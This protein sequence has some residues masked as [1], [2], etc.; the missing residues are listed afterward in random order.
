MADLSGFWV[1]DRPL[2]LLR[3]HSGVVI[4]LAAVAAAALLVKLLPGSRRDS[5]AGAARRA[6]T[7]VKRAFTTN[8]Q[9][10]LLATTAFVLSCASG[11]TTWDGMRNFTGEP[12]LSFMVTFGIQG[13]MLII[14]WIIGES[15]ASGMSHRPSRRGREGGGEPSA[16]SRIE[17]AVGLIVGTLFAI[18][19]FAAVANGLGAFESRVGAAGVGTGWSAFADKALYAGVGLL[20]IATLV[21]NSRSDIAQPYVQSARIIAKNAVLWVM[22][23]ACM[24]TSVFFSFD[25]LF[26]SI[27][28]QDERKRAAEIRAVNQ[29]AGVVADI[30]VL[31]QR[32]QAEE[33]DA[34]F[35]SEG[36]KRYDDNLTRLAKES[37]GAEK[38]IEGFFVEQMEARRR[39][40]AEQQ[41]RIATSQSGQAGLVSKKA[42]MTD[43]LS[44]LKA[45]RPELA[46]ILAKVKSE[47]DE[48]A[49]NLDAKRIEAQAEEK[50]AEGTLKQGRGPQWR[51]RMAELARLQEAYK[52]QEE[53][54]REAQKR[55]AAVDTRLAQLERELAAVDGDIAKLKGE[56]ATA[57]QRITVAEQAKATEEG[58]PKVDPARVR[59]AFERA[60]ADFVR[61]PTAER[62]IGLTSQCIQLLGAMTATPATKER[63]RAIDCDAKQAAE[64][65]GR[66]FALNAGIQT[67]AQSCAGGDKLPQTGGTDALLQFGRKCLQ[68][69]GLPSRDS[70]EMAG[71]ISSIDLNRDDK[72]HRFVVT[73]NAFLDG[74]RLAYLALAIAIAIDSLVFMSGLFGANAVRSPLTDVPSSKARSAEQLEAVIENALLP[75]K[76]ENARIALEAMHATTGRPGFVAEVDTAEL[77]PDSRR[78]VQ[79][80]LTAGST[81]GAVE[82]DAGRRTRYH[83][84]GELYEFLAIVAKR[85]FEQNKKRF[86]EDIEQSHARAEFE[87]VMTVALLPQEEIGYNCDLVLSHLTPR[88]DADKKTGF[89]SEIALPQYQPSGPMAGETAEDRAARLA[90]NE[91]RRQHNA[92]DRR[93]MMR[94][95]NA[96]ATFSF[97]QPVMDAATRQRIPDAYYVHSELYKMLAR[98]RARSLT[99]AGQQPPS[100]PPSQPPVRRLREA[101]PP[102]IEPTQVRPAIG[103]RGDQQAYRDAGDEP[104]PTARGEP[105]PPRSPRAP[106]EPVPHATILP[107]IP[108]GTAPPPPAAAAAEAPPPPRSR[109][110]DSRPRGT[111][112]ESGLKNQ[113]RDELIQ[114]GGLFPWDARD[115]AVAARLGE[116]SEPEAALRRLAARAPRLGRLVS[117][118][119]EDYR[120]SVRQAYEDLQVRNDHQP[121]I[122][123]QVLETVR[124]ELIQ[125]MPLLMLS[126]GG[127]YQQILDHMISQLEPQDGDGLLSPNDQG[128][129]ARARMQ[130]E[131]LKRLADD[132]R[133][134]LQHV[135]RIIDQ[136][137]ER[138]YSPFDRQPQT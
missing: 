90:E 98:I 64:A 49:R 83:I 35:K 15:F 55:L 20:L 133:H 95:L 47:L 73:W 41:E 12:I 68:D 30:G 42:T 44:R 14:A 28:P 36:W 70:A 111:E 97:V 7:A 17:P 126:P 72:A 85:T 54:V 5:S 89:T 130:V 103:Y 87:R 109:R 101:P 105:E 123:I 71:K 124:D 77:D 82:Q 34:L 119:V 120:A 39:A 107:S 22:F 122:Y 113:I 26:S 137:D 37:Q 115:L 59:N 116:D 112:F 32:R 74:N 24:A 106:V 69:S 23:L 48:R 67:F 102:V 78:R 29:V 62:L 94:V 13:V 93:R 117:D 63:V 6:W 50:G 80:L 66:V 2:Q 92:D 129:L 40:I 131:A 38:L 96:G 11:W 110:V 61:G 84:R 91:H 27:F 16:W 53:R 60:R 65:A 46:G 58:G 8:W 127:P 134:R 135:A 9:L 88:D 86:S 138:A 100:L 51:E 136:Y 43:E 114:L 25:S 104:A 57:E 10:T 79:R 3:D 76:F 125:L 31:M 1:I 18:T 108:L 75:E 99:L 128:V 121:P 81:I 21:I 132:D 4:P 19:L 52:I 33:A 56:A 118:A 45:E